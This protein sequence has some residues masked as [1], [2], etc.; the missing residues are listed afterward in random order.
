MSSIT[1]THLSSPPYRLD[2]PADSWESP[3][4]RSVSSGWHAYEPWAI[5]Q[6]NRETRQCRV[7]IE[8]RHICSRWHCKLRELILTLYQTNQLSWK[9]SHRMTS[10]KAT[11]PFAGRKKRENSYAHE[12]KFKTDALFSQPHKY[13]GSRSSSHCTC[14]QHSTHKA[15][16]CLSKHGAF[17]GVS[18][19]KNNIAEIP[20]AKSFQTA[21][22]TAPI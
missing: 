18:A 7:M 21:K 15:E 16:F 12:D 5:R 10:T 6:V 2:Q 22:L 19:K 3:S 1:I 14:E 8:S 20:G 9:V 17:F 4:W 13:I 11:V